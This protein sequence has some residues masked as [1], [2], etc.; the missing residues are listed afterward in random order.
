MNTQVFS[1]F[2]V[3]PTNFEQYFG[4]VVLVFLTALV[5]LS[6]KSSSVLKY[7]LAAAGMVLMI[8]Y[9]KT[10]FQIHSDPVYTDELP[11]ELVLSLKDNSSRVVLENVH[12]ASALGMVLPRQRLT[13]LSYTQTFPFAAGKYFDNYLCVKQKINAKKKEISDRY[14]NALKT[15]D[16]AY[17]YQNA[18]FVLLHNKRKIRFDV[19]FDLSKKPQKCDQ[20][21]LLFS[22]EK[23]E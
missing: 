7:A 16:R 21:P 2:I 15:L 3:S 1:G 5:V 18:D 6:M 9:T 4:V 19:F 13:A 22:L 11:E 12:L 17:K 14:Q 20:A 8:L 10:I 23:R